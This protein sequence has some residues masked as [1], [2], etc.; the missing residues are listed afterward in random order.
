[1]V[2]QVVEK[3]LE[4]LQTNIT[5]L[6][7]GD[8]IINTLL[9]FVF[10]YFF[11]VV[12]KFW[13]YFV[14]ILTIIFFILNLAY[15]FYKNKYLEVENKVPELSERLRTVADNVN[16]SNPI[17]D[18]LKEDVVKGM[19][20][21]KTAY[22]INYHWVAVKI[23][24]IAIISILIVVA[25]FLNVNFQFSFSKIPF[26]SQLRLAGQDVANLNLS[27]SEGNLSELY[28][29]KSIARLGNKQL[30]LFLNPLESD[31][32]INSIKQVTK[33]DF[34]APSF[35]KEIY[36]SYDVSYNDKIAK[37]NQKLVKSYFEQISR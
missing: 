33:E 25:S 19:S 15:I 36:T 20:K 5:L 32:D 34:N 22:F 17:I 4:E 18:S 10:I 23:L 21:I 2:T 9:V 29:N 12:F 8:G 14:L 3:A 16:K 30:S 26:A 1:M 11:S 7:L 37:E 28:G 6:E 27:Y 31:A 35:P 13:F 24:A